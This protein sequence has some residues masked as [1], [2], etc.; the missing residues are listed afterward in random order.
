HLRAGFL[1]TAGNN[2]KLQYRYTYESSTI[3]NN[4]LTNGSFTG[5]ADRW[6]F[7]SAWSYGSNKITFTYVGEVIFV[8]P[9]VTGS[10]Y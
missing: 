10:G 8:N 3:G 2:G 9:G 7:G 5:S 4:L 6:V 1:T